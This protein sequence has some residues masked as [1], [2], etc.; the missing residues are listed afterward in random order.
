M[1]LS[2][3]FYYITHTPNTKKKNH[4]GDVTFEQVFVKG[5]L[6]KS[7]KYETEIKLINAENFLGKL[8]LHGEVVYGL[9]FLINYLPV[10]K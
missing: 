6:L 5:R 2:I 1:P 10:V 7:L 3:P 8:N 9:L 4:G